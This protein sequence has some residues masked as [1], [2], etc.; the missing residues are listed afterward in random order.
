MCLKKKKSV[1]TALKE[2][3][4][5]KPNSSILGLR[6]KLYIYNLAGTPKKEKDGATG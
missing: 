4:R 1:K 2:V 3:L 6:P 5:P